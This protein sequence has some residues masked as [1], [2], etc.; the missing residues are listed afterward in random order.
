MSKKVKGVVS[1]KRELIS[2]KAIEKAKTLQSEKAEQFISDLAPFLTK[3]GEVRKNL[4]ATKREQFNRIVSEYKQNAP[5]MKKVKEWKQNIY[6]K[7]K[8]Q[9]FFSSKAGQRKFTNVMNSDAVKGL[10]Q[11][12]MDSDQIVTLFKTFSHVSAKNIINA[13]EHLLDKMEHDVPEEAQQY[14][15]QDDAYM[16]LSDFLAEQFGYDVDDEEIPFI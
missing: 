16:E 3:N 1:Y 9:G 4:S 5:T 2:A 12:G 6:E 13:A 11:K 14:L 15:D 10:I 7:G 8:Q